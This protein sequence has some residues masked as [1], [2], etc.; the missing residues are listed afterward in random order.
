MKKINMFFGRLCGLALNSCLQWVLIL[1]FFVNSYILLNAMR[2]ARVR[3]T[4]RV[5]GSR[6][7]SRNSPQSFGKASGAAAFLFVQRFPLGLA[8]CRGA[9]SLSA[10]SIVYKQKKNQM[11]K[12]M[13]T[14]PDSPGFAWY[15]DV[16]TMR[17]FSS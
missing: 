10:L 7:M 15:F 14:K 1:M 3:Q 16:F 6:T 5:V 2:A 4:G 8:D 12:S 9:F 11:N 17:F 13:T